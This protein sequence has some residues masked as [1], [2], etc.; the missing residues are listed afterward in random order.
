MAS[1]VWEVLP[2]E[3]ATTLQEWVYGCDGKWLG[4][5][6]VFFIHRN[7]TTRENLW[8][9][10]MGSETYEAIGR[11]CKALGDHLHHLPMGAV[12]DWKGSI[13]AA[14]ASHFGSIPHQRCLAHLVRQAKRLLP[15][16]SP[17]AATQ[18]LRWIA[19]NITILETSRDPAVWNTLLL[20]WEKDYGAMLKEKTIAPT[21]GTRHWWYTHGNLRRAWRLLT[22]DQDPL[23]VFLINPL[24]PKTNNALEGVNSNLKQKL[25]DHRGMKVPRQA[26]FLCWYMAFSRSKSDKDLK[27]LWVY[28]KSKFS[29]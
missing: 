23:F 13:V 15:L 1:E 2:P 29:R 3:T 26:A 10:F 24:I 25:G 19:E 21:G 14:V 27:K 16:N 7:V 4:R 18:K 17:F 12:S 20:R 22:Y 8:W 28:W 5:A 11:D 6:G 9:S